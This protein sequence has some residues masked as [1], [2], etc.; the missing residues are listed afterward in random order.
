[1][2]QDFA[3][4]LA[5]RCYFSKQYVLLPP[6]SFHHCHYSISNLNDVSLFSQFFDFENYIDLFDS[7]EEMNERSSNNVYVKICISFQSDL[8]DRY[9]WVRPEG[10]TVGKLTILEAP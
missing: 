6:F 2:I 1:M 3:L 8:A 7:R 9:Y 4:Y 10:T 5:R